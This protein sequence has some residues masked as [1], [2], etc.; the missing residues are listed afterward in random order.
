MNTNSDRIEVR[1]QLDPWFRSD[2]KL[3]FYQVSV[4]EGIERVYVAGTPTMTQLTQDAYGGEV[5]PT[6]TLTLEDAQQLADELY[7]V[8]VRPTEGAG[9]VGQLAAVK[10]H[11]ADM[12]RLV[13]EK[14]DKPFD[15]RQVIKEELEAIGR[16]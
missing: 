12:R 11:L 1:A 4:R 8:G 5:Q 2:I 13:F 14:P 15:A 10:E 7:R 9:S 16:S 6:M 3:R